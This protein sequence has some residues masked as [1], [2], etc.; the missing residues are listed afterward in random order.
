MRSD[1]GEKGEGE[2]RGNKKRPHW[3]EK[4]MKP[5]NQSGGGVSKRFLRGPKECRGG[6]KGFW[7]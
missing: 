2:K 3:K 5:A 7:G 6:K 1:S 4:L